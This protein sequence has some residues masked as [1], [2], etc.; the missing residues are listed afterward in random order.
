[1]GVVELA[2]LVGLVG[3]VGSVGSVELLR[4]ELFEPLCIA[5]SEVPH[6]IARSIILITVVRDVAITT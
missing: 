5:V 6:S 3:L 4:T 2:G 1:V